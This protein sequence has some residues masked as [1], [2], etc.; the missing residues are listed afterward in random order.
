MEL[1][2]WVCTKPG[3]GPC[4]WGLLCNPFMDVTCHLPLITLQLSPPPLPSCC[5]RL[6][7]AA[8]RSGPRDQDEAG[9]RGGDTTCDS[10]YFS[11]VSTA[12]IS[13]KWDKTNWRQHVGADV[14]SMIHY[15][16]KMTRCMTCFTGWL[17]HLQSDFHQYYWII[18]VNQLLYLDKSYM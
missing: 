16:S 15:W 18:E 14:R 7:A 13:Q 11:V 6:I 10:Q 17:F 5:Y 4:L 3:L 9:R 2:I 12:R 8:F 1:F